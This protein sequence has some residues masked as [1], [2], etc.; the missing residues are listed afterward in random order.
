MTEWRPVVG[1][2]GIY[3]VSDTGEVRSV[4]YVDQRGSRRRGRTMRQSTAK[5]GH[6]WIQLRDRK[7]VGVHRL[8]LLAFV[9]PC[10]EGMEACHINGDPADNRVEN[11]RWDTRS[12]NQRDRV[13]HGTNHNSIK[14][15]CPQGH[16]YDNNNTYTYPDGRR[17]CRACSRRDALARYHEKESAA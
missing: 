8:V 17:K 16:P 3:Q 2:E 12:E 6:K 4:S 15:H 1:H 11:L 13:R 7:S 9:G 5:S 10:P 14:T